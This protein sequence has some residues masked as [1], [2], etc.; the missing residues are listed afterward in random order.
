M[1]FF[2]GNNNSDDVSRYDTGNEEISTRELKW[3]K[4]YLKHKMQ[5]RKGVVV[6]L[7]LFCLVTLGGS[8][9][10]WSYYYASGYWADKKI[11]ANE[12]RQ[13][14]NYR[15]IQPLYKAKPIEVD[16][17]S[18]LDTPSGKYNVVA[19]LRNV[20][21]RWLGEVTFHFNFPGGRTESKTVTVLPRQRSSRAIFGVDNSNITQGAEFVLDD[22]KWKKIDPHEI[23]YV[24]NYIKARSQFSIQNFNF[25]G[26]SD[27]A[28]A[29]LSFTV[30]NETAYSYWDGRFLVE[31]YNGNSLVA[32]RDINIEKFITGQKRDVSL[33]FLKNINITRVKLHPKINFF[34][35]DSYMAPPS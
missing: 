13:F 30:E 27:E 26:S 14:Q 5:I 9:V 11:A 8:L 7:F 16:N 19:E 33:T 3:G 24:E 10:Y 21:L 34:S 12:V 2:G 31:L 35:Q 32:V 28:P 4:W 29:N 17:I 23:R 25:T 22:M 1:N 15:N 18:I 6:F 20:N